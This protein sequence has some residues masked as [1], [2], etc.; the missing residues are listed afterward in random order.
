MWLDNYLKN[1]HPHSPKFGAV[2]GNS[3]CA[4]AGPRSATEETRAAPNIISSTDRIFERLIG[5]KSD[6]TGAEL[7]RF[8]DAEKFLFGEGNYPKP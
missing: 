1:R 3:S 6:I 5:A 8:A 7:D 2:N 4:H